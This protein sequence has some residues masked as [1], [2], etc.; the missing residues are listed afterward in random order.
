M[1]Q[2]SAMT[3]ARNDKVAN[4]PLSVAL[5]GPF[6]VRVYGRPLPCPLP[7]KEQ[8]LLALLVLR[9]R[10]GVERLWLAGTL[11]PDSSSEQALHNLRNSL[12]HLRR[13][14]GPEGHRL[15]SPSSRTLALDLSGATIDVVAFDAAVAHGDP[16]SLEEGVALYAGPLLDGCGEEWVFQE[17]R[18]REEAYLEALETLARRAWE[19]GELGTAERHLRRVVAEDPLRESAQRALM[20]T[21]ADSGNY[22][23]ALDVYRDLRLRLHQELSV[24]P[25]PETVALFEGL[26]AEARRKAVR[27]ARCA[28]RG[29]RAKTPA[30][31]GLKPPHSTAPHTAHASGASRHNLPVPLT[32]FIGREPVMAAV[33]RLLATTHLLTLT[34]AGGCGK[35]RLALQVA[36]D[37]VEAY[38]DGVW[39]VELAALADHTLVPQAVAA[40]L[41]VREEPGRPLTATLMDSLRC[42]SLLLVLD[43]CEHLLSG[44]ARLVESLLR[45]CPRLRILAT[46]REG[47]RVS[48]EQTYRVPSLSVPDPKCLP[49]PERLQESEAVRLFADRAGLSQPG[50]AVTAANA[51]AVVQVCRR[52]DGIPLAIEMAASRVKALPVEK[53]ADRLDDRFRLL[54]GG[55][56]A[57]LPRQQTLKALIDWSYDLLSPPEQALLR[58]LSVFA[59]GWTLEAAKQVCAGEGIE[60]LEVLDRL[61]ALVEKSLVLFE[62]HLGEPRYRLLETVQ[63]YGRDRLME[64][65]EREPVRHRHLQFFLELAE[66]AEPELRG[67]NQVAWF[68]RLDREHNN[69]RGALE[70]SR[71]SADPELGQRLAGALWWFWAIRGHWQEGR[72]WLALALEQAGPA[73]R[74]PGRAKALLAAVDLMSLTWEHEL[75]TRL[76]EEA[77]ALCR[78]LEDQRGAALALNLLGEQRRDL[79]ESAPLWEQSLAL[80]LEAGDHW[81]AVRSLH[82]LA[83]VAKE[84]GEATRALAMLEESVALSRA[85]GDPRG[86]AQSLIHLAH[87]AID[88][89][90]YSRADR[91]LEESLALSRAIDD[92]LGV[93]QSL[94][95]MTRSAM[96][97][98][99]YDRASAVGAEALAVSRDKGYAPII[100]FILGLLAELAGRRGENEEAA[101][102]YGESLQMWATMSA[103]APVAHHLAR[104]GEVA[105]ARDEPERAARLFG[106][107]EA[108]REAF[109]PQAPHHWASRWAPREQWIATIRSSLG[110]EAFAAAWAAGRAM[111]LEQAIAY[112]LAE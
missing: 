20:Q 36:A 68:N 19:Q 13:A 6:T 32:S 11:W 56:R 91:L 66:E 63:Q 15:Q 69:L 51:A 86:T 80:A 74:T 90:E 33:K 23:K 96:C 40:V 47:L 60:A 89:E 28:H 105:V 58:R 109:S 70:W 110:E 37:R 41:G 84:R 55:S 10:D 67:P 2:R 21:L 35:T 106:A 82:G 54:T 5:F 94:Q 65:C 22:A 50:F 81:V 43:N 93:I 30:L 3:G 64:A 49:S 12:T 100:A 71:L 53:I 52:L 112:A 17:R 101:C 104:L 83:F 39:L 73:A 45:A 1:N 27:G 16:A 77:L 48:G 103:G 95:E 26:R 111:T 38:G 88:Q 87:L 108:R 31:E 18:V 9:A 62:D 44:C 59:G 102:L 75:A 25:D 76:G 79:E 14:L 42:R 7:R 29:V 92:R 98:G 97:Q 34:G 8:W 61:T 46:S 72:D 85:L 78:E 57:A 24:A 107:A 4:S 99:E